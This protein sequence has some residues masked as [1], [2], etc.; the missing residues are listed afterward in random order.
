MENEEKCTNPEHEK[1]LDYLDGR[2]YHEYEKDVERRLTS[3][4][5]PHEEYCPTPEAEVHRCSY[6]HCN[7]CGYCN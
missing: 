5:Q 3:Y 1:P 2:S 7:N 6:L 4:L